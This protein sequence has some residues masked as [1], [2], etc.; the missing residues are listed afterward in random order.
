MESRLG[1]RRAPQG[2]VRVWVWVRIPLANKLNWHSRFSF[3][4]LD[5]Q[6]SV[7]DCFTDIKPGLRAIWTRCERFGRVL[8]LAH[9]TRLVRT[10]V[11]PVSRNDLD[12]TSVRPLCVSRAVGIRS[13]LVSW[14]VYFC[15]TRTHQVK[16]APRK[17]LGRFSNDGSRL[18]LRQG[19]ESRW[20]SE[21]GG[22]SCCH[23]EM[24]DFS[25]Q[26]WI[27][28]PSFSIRLAYTSLCRR[29]E[30]NSGLPPWWSRILL[31][32]DVPF[33]FSASP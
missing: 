20:L 13:P 8:S 23:F 12:L 32:F 31:S 14:G 9:C 10:E 27:L 21:T 4:M 16:P 5:S 22:C 2:F 11:K 7:L 1:I 3:S 15:S 18:K 6:S 24:F 30:L 29:T 25:S 17:R 28:S 33:T 26:R 19:F